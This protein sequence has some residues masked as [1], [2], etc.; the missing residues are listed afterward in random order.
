[1]RHP[2]NMQKLTRVAFLGI[3]ACMIITGTVWGITVL[4]AHHNQI[5]AQQAGNAAHEAIDGFPMTGD[6]AP[7]FTLIDQFGHSVTLASLRGHEVVLAFIDSRCK[8][9]CPLTAQIMY[10][11]KARLNASAARKVDLVAVNANPTATS[12]ALVQAWSIEHGML[13]QWLFLTGTAKQLQSVYRLYH[14]YVQVDASGRDVHDPIT[15]IIDA[16]GRERLSFETLGSSSQSD[17]GDEVSGLA[18]GMQQWLP[19]PQ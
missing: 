11:A 5:T 13:R 8:D 17:L 14:V 6:P 18:D 15:F 4:I 19:Q 7:D 12:T 1:M 9:V 2:D 3:L 10:D 16:Q